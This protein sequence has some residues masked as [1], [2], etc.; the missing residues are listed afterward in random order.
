MRQPGQMRG[1]KPTAYAQVKP[2]LGLQ[3]AE[4]RVSGSLTPVDLVPIRFG[5]TEACATSGKWAVQE[6]NLQPWA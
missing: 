3:I 1:G 2:L 5:A 6:S 4:L